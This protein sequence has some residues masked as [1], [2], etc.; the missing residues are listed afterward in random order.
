M[1]AA[2]I[3]A[4]LMDIVTI[5]LRNVS[6]DAI[7]FVTNANESGSGRKNTLVHSIEVRIDV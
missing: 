4:L 6:T 1:T 2:V 7:R 3:N 5:A